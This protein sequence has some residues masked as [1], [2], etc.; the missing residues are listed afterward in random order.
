VP[1]IGIRVAGRHAVIEGMS[2][3]KGVHS[4][5]NEL[6]WCQLD[7]IRISETLMPSGLQLGE[8][9][10]EAG[11]ICFVLEGDYR[12]CASDGDHRFYPGALQFRAPGEP[13]SNIFSSELD[14]LTLLISIDSDRWVHIGARRPVTTD[15]IL[16]DCADEIRR[17]LR[18]LDDARRAALEG[19]AM[20]SLSALAR[21]YDN[22]DWRE[23]PWLREAVAMINQ[24]ATGPISLTTVATAIGVHRATLAAAFRQFKNTSV[25]KYIREQRVRH[26]MRELVSSKMPLCEIAT[27]CGFH[28]QAHMGLVF[29][30][31]VGM[32][33]GVYRSAH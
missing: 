10:H 16:K 12:E 8:H 14:V 6:R 9:S 7:G 11:Q 26:V 1:Q 25:G 19:W 13:H 15:A 17:E 4:F 20:L 30:K 24:G 3:P 27:K 5:G 33:P 22:I 23:P 31:A 18:R 29:R 32:S 21:R 2:T 28:D